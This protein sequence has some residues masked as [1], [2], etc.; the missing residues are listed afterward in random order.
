MVRCILTDSMCN[1]QVAR[2]QDPQK[3]RQI[4]FRLLRLTFLGT[5]VAVLCLLCIPEWIFTDYLFSHEFKG[6]TSVIRG[7]SVGIVAFG[8]HTILSQYLIA[9]GHVRYSAASSCI[10]LIVLLVAGFFLI[11]AYGISGA[12]VTSSLAFSSMAGFSFWAFQET[13]L[14]K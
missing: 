14:R 7:L 13:S 2:E 6:I 4:T 5:L 3:Q 9:S 1:I 10:G 12:A 11:P 8:C